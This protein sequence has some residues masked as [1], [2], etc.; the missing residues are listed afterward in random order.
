MCN[1]VDVNNLFKRI[2]KIMIQ[3]G[4]QNSIQTH[5]NTEFMHLLDLQTHLDL[6][7]DLQ[8]YEFVFM[9]RT[10]LLCQYSTNRANIILHNV[11]RTDLDSKYHL[12]VTVESGNTLVCNHICRVE[13]KNTFPY[14]FI[15]LFFFLS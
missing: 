7:F 10:N 4:L 11:I 8:F 15:F 1:K 3:T 13:G 9:N 6:Q 12:I 2:Q 14:F 5:R